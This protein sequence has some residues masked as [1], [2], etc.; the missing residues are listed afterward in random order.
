MHTMS[1]ANILSGFKVKCVSVLLVVAVCLL[2]VPLSFAAF[3]SL[4]KENFS[5]S[6]TI[7]GGSSLP[8]PPKPDFYSAGFPYI[9]YFLDRALDNTLQTDYA[10]NGLTRSFQKYLGG[11]TSGDVD[12]IT[13]GASAYDQALLGRISLFNGETTILDTYINYYYQRSDANNPL[14]KCSDGYTDASGNQILYGP[15]R[16]VRIL[17]RNVV[18]WWNTWDW[19]VDTGAAAVLIMYA[20]EAYNKTQNQAYKD[21]SILLGE[22]M[23]KLQDTDGGLRYGPI[24]MPHPTGDYYFWNL[25]S[26]EQNERALYAFEALYK[27]TGDIAYQQ[28]IDSIKTWLKSMY[29]FNEHLYHSA[30]SYESGAW[31]K[32]AF[33]YIATDV[34]ALAPLDM[35]FDDAFFGATQGIRDQEVD[36]MFSVIESKT[37][38]FDVQSK[39]I[40][41]RFS[42]SQ[43]GNYGSVEISSQMALAYLRASQI[44]HDRGEDTIAAEYLDRYNVL[45][46]SLENFF[47]V[48]SDDTASY[49][50]PYSSYLD[51]SVAGNVPTGTGF[52]TYNC[53]AALASSYFAF[54]KTGY[55]PYIYDGGSG[56][57]N[58]GPIVPPSGDNDY[59]DIPNNYD[60]DPDDP[61][62]AY[63]VGDNGLTSLENYKLT[64]S[65]VNIFDD[66][67]G[68][69]L[70]ALPT[71]GQ[72]PLNVTFSATTATIDVVKYEWDFDGNGVY[73]RWHYATEGSA[74]SY[75][76]T[77]AG[78][79]NVRIRATNSLGNIDIAA[80]TVTVSN[81]TSSPTAQLA[82]GLLPYP[83]ANEIIISSLKEL[84]ATAS[85][86]N[87]IVRYQWDTTGDGEY[88]MSSSKSA[89]MTRTYNE[90]ISK[91]FSGGIKVTDSQGLSGIAQ[92]SIMSNATK[93]DGSLYRPKVFLN[94]YIVRGVAGTAV[95]LG[96][97]GVPAGG[98]SYGYAKKLEWDF[99]G[100]GINDW[101]SSIENPSWTGFADVTHVYGAPGVYRAILKAHTE[102][103]LSSYNSALVIIAGSEPSL[104]AKAT[105]SYDTTTNVTEIDG[106]SPVKAIFNHSLST[107]TIA[108]YEWDFDGDKN[109]D[110]TTTKSSDTPIYNYHFPG[111][112]VAML[113]VTDANGLIDAF[114]IPV[115]SEYPVGFYSSY[116]KI[117][118]E[119]DTIAGNSISLVSEVFPDD[120]SVNEVMFQYRKLGDILWTDIGKGT[121]VMSYSTTWDTT[122]LINGQSYEIRAAVNGVDSTSFKI[123]S[124]IV[125]NSASSPDVYENNNGTYV[126]KQ[127]IDPSQSNEIV[128]PDGTR[129][130]I[131]QGA[132]PNDG[133]L[134]DVTIEEV[135]V[136]GAGG[137]IDINITGTSTFLKD[138]TISIAY[139]DADNN[140]IVDG[141]SINE[142]DLKLRWYND[143]TG[144]WEV[145]YDSVVYPNENYVS[146]TVNHLTIFGWGA[147]AV[148]AAAGGTGSASSDGS[149][150]ASYCFI[151]TAAYG[152]PMADDVVA[153]RQ[154]RDKYLMRNS[155]GREFVW[156]Y[157][158]YSPPIANF[159]SSRPGLKR[160]TRLLLR[161]LV[162][163]AKKRV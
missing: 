29:D 119:G 20:A 87:E 155:L 116:V 141:T 124:L 152:T 82:G 129:I 146:A 123:I 14:L 81:S 22:Y 43:T 118:Q 95:S 65:G 73:D 138:I 126:K 69:T 4:A 11:G 55:I 78:T 139:P 148:A 136:S 68:I 158:R 142:N 100:D 31:V 117:P 48:A 97:Y 34:M 35:M 27:M 47:K 46:A 50:A 58:V 61:Y 159:I 133:T 75:K 143:S 88:D 23:S 91:I 109:I 106:T 60:A 26:T 64:V 101:S 49:I 130:D 41:F 105:V 62:N 32:T 7:G 80:A 21:F 112:C 120:S 66:T 77:A 103:S 86:S 111:Y 115:F 98:N 135:V 74:I 63:E 153:L 70:S 71:S 90:T 113:R 99:E 156:N 83:I 85:G 5:A 145:L 3:D 137:T 37:A 161:P 79:Y 16:I 10:F 33:S 114:Y 125:D 72:L 150:T 59:D 54:A 45:V 53:E 28:A 131:P 1:R 39:S 121:P 92:M 107:G 157:Y 144:L 36:E 76:Y 147:A 134:P 104:R 89:D 84:K 122:G 2:D 19:S 163:F 30:A 56:I 6:V 40:F 13:S 110:Y 94:S 17:N 127:I 38:F 9:K 149:S 132:L 42:I 57:P 15:F 24:G 12:L 160:I 96:G 93:W 140:G 128:L 162:K 18:D 67:I 8:Y 108:K 151:A 102:S 51:K 25:K 52:D 154:F 44:Y